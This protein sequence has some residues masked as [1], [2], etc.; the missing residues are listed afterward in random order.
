MGQGAEVMTSTET[1]LRKDEVRSSAQIDRLAESHL[2][3]TMFGPGHDS[4]ELDFGRLERWLLHEA[5]VP[6]DAARKALATIGGRLANL[7]L[8]KP[9][10]HLILQWA[11]E[12]LAQMG[13]S[14]EEGLRQALRLDLNAVE[15]SIYH[16]TGSLA[17]A[18]QNPEATSQKLAGLIK[19]QFA[20]RKVFQREIAE[21]HAQGDL[22]IL[23]AC[24]V[25]RPDS[26]FLTPDYVKLLGLPANGRAPSAAPARRAHVLL[27]HL[28]RFTHELRCHVAGTVQWGFF[29]TLLLPYL[30]EL[31]DADLRQFAQQLLFE[32]AQLEATRG[33]AGSRIQLDLDF[34]MP[35]YLEATPAIGPGGLPNGRLMGEYRA[36]LLRFNQALIEALDRGDSRSSPFLNPHILFHFNQGQTAWSSLHQQLFELAARWGQPAIAFSSRFRDCGPMGCWSTSQPEWLRAVRQ[37]NDLRGF[38]TCSIALNLPR[39]FWLSQERSWQEALDGQMAL[40]AT[41]IRQKR[42][43]LSRL[44]A[45]GS[46]GPLKFLRHRFNDQPFL[47]MERATQLVQWVGLG[48]LADLANRDALGTPRGRVEKAVTLVERL[49]GALQLMSMTHKWRLLGSECSDEGAPYR[50]AALDLKNHGSQFSA[51]LLPHANQTEPCYSTL[52]TLLADRSMDWRERFQLE[53]K[54]HA[55]ALTGQ[56]LT[57]FA[58]KPQF[59]DDLV[60]QKM[61]NLAQTCELR[62][63]RIVP[64]MKTCTECHWIFHDPVRQPSC[65]QCASLLTADFGWTTS[66]FSP[67]PTWYRGKRAEWANR[68]RYDSAED[69]NRQTSL[70]W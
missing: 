17:G 59:A 48:E 7:G 50:M 24:D 4:G 43:F 69:T 26:L 66:Q 27:G 53:G 29:N 65:P 3:A 2:H 13:L 6:A 28:V 39:L 63:L 36:E 62:Q 32:F 54:L 37:P 18:N 55:F 45:Y 16:P 68:L 20:F 22:E 49:H 21:A 58:R 60:P 19:S 15:W 5:G 51:Y 42:R 1:S 44:M 25:D 70:P 56:S 8:D 38:S 35:P 31:S 47:R 12:L 41:A 9:S 11:S 10:P 61:F 64:D 14:L 23:H 57:L 30:Q 34:D 33:V 40:V 67:V 52:S 46:R